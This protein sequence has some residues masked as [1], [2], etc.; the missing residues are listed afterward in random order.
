MCISPGTFLLLRPVGQG[1]RITVDPSNRYGE[2]QRSTRSANLG[3]D[4]LNSSG[5]PVVAAADGKVVVAGDDSK[6]IYANRTNIY[7]KLVVLEHRLPG[8]NEPVFTLY[9]HLSEIL[10]KAGD[11]V[12]AGQEIGKVGMTGNVGGSTLHF[13]VRLGENSPETTR[14]PELWLAPLTDKSGEL[15]GALAGSIQDAEGNYIQMGNVVLEWL[16]GPGQP[17]RG[18]VYIKTYS[19]RKMRGRTPWEESF[20]VSELPPGRYQV[21]FWLGGM[22]QRLVEVEP[23]KLTV[24]RFNIK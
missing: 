16:A 19:D 9:A 2:Y 18:Q 7:G 24:V 10:V 8:I 5:V 20:A 11:T 3:V 12:T 1:G 21:S 17:A 13:E 15:S 6:T 22:Q 14:N 23:G 4:F